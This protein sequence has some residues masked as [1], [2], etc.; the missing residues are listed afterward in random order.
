MC[1]CCIGRLIDI[2]GELTVK[3]DFSVLHLSHC[4]LEHMQFVIDIVI[5]IPR[6][7]VLIVTKSDF[8]GL[9]TSCII[10]EGFEK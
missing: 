6:S 9:G 4:L 2:E 8:D 5:L 7:K 1:L 10:G 3:R